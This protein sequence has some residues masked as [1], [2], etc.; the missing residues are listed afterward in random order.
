MISDVVADTITANGR[1]LSGVRNVTAAELAGDSGLLTLTPTTGAAIVIESGAT[2]RGIKL[3]D[4]PDPDTA[5]AADITTADPDHVIWFSLRASSASPVWA[6]NEDLS[7]NPEH[8][9]RILNSFLPGV[10]A[11]GAIAENTILLVYNHDLD[12]WS[13][14]WSA[15]SPLTPVFS[16]AGTATDPAGAGITYTATVSSAGTTE[17]GLVSDSGAGVTINAQTGVMSGGAGAVAGDYTITLVAGN[18]L[19]ASQ[20]VKTVVWTVT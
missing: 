14:S 12:R 13:V 6:M 20:A 17:F 7:V 16:S 18:M 11:D 4:Y 9:L 10:T 8:R 1:Q 5:I 19:A 2:L 3:A 15:P